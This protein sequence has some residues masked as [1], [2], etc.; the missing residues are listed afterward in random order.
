M[1]EKTKLTVDEVKS[2]EL[3]ILKYLDKVFKENNIQYYL[4]GGTLLG[5][6]RHKGFIPWDDDIDIIIKR[7]DY[8]K[9]LMTLQNANTKYKVLSRYFNKEYLYP[10]AKVIDSTT[11]LI[12]KDAIPVK[13]LGI[14]VDIFP[15]DSLPDSELERKKFDDKIHFYRQIAGKA[16]TW[17][18]KQCA[19]TFK[20]RVSCFFS[21]LYGW[22]RA[23][24]KID[25]ICT[26]N[27]SGKTKYSLDIVAAGKR[28]LKALSSDFDET[29]EVEFEGISFPAPA[30]YDDYLTTLYGDYMKLP[31]IDK[32]VSNH[33]FIAYRL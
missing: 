13:S 22:Q 18:L 23:L 4:D 21:Y 10:F 14:C 5:A 27:Y 12:E 24:D 32:R 33:N 7:C 19:P 8:K 3:N 16:E 20:N 30:G 6:I 29:I 1:M 17:I 31:P 2:I 11:R 26:E 9:A 15:L 25:K 28:Y